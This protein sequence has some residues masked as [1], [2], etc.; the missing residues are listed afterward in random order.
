MLNSLIKICKILPYSSDDLEY[1]NVHYDNF[2]LEL[3]ET[4]SFTEEQDLPTLIIGWNKVREIFPEQSIDNPKI[5]DNLFWTFSL[6]EKDGKNKTDIKMFLEFSMK[7]FFNKNI[8]C[9]YI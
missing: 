3:I 5:S 9:E 4:I 6:T 8:I 1:I 7:K 2:A